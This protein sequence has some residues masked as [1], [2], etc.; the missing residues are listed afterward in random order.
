[1]EVVTAYRAING[2]LFDTQKKC[3]E[4]ERK[5]SEYPKQSE[6]V[7]QV[8]DDYFGNKLP[9]YKHTFKIKERYNIPAKVR[10]FYE[11]RYGE[12]SY[13]I[14]AN[15]NVIFGLIH[16]SSCGKNI[17]DGV[18]KY[19]RELIMFGSNPFSDGFLAGLQNGL[20]S[21][22]ENI[23]KMYRHSNERIELSREIINDEVVRF[24]FKNACGA[25]PNDVAEITTSKEYIISRLFKFK[26]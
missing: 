2:K 10:E 6:V 25:I 5:L 24:E 15:E 21:W 22:N 16:K 4:Y 23:E 9:I 14:Y 19:I 7:E 3:E 1:M 17:F 26:N 8:E 20:Y 11:V 18:G 13:Y 12:N